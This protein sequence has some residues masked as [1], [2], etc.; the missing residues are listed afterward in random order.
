M[1]IELRSH[2]DARATD[3]YNVRLSESR[4]RAAYDYLIA[5]GVQPSR[6]VARGY[7]ETEIVNGCVDG[8]NCSENEHQQNRRTEFKIV[9]VQ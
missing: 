6:I 9:A 4:A 2:T 5:R 8:V 3:L 7:G 1:R